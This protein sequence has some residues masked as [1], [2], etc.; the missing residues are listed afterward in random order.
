MHHQHLFIRLR[1]SFDA[2]VSWRTFSNVTAKVRVLLKRDSWGVCVENLCLFVGQPSVYCM[3][4]WYFPFSDKHLSVCALAPSWRTSLQETTAIG[5]RPWPCWSLLVS[6]WVSSVDHLLLVWLL[7]SWRLSYPFTC[8][9]RLLHWLHRETVG[10]KPLSSHS[11]WNVA[12]HLDFQF[13]ITWRSSPSWETSPCWRQLCFSSCP[14]A[15]SYWLKPAGSQV[16]TVH[17]ISSSLRDTLI[18]KL[19]NVV[20]GF[21]RWLFFSHTHSFF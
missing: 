16:E 21:L 11:S 19:L 9:L 20:K 5:L 3:I 1:H 13:F 15:P 2:K 6:F 12:V 17:S 10:W 8:F 7:E 14:G 4:S 18:R